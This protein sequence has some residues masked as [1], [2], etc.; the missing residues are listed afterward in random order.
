MDADTYLRSFRSTDSALYARMRGQIP[1]HRE[2]F[3]DTATYETIAVESLLGLLY[4][5]GMV[6]D[7]S[8][9]YQ[10]GQ[11]F[12]DVV[13]HEQEMVAGLYD[14]FGSPAM[15]KL[16]ELVGDGDAASVEGALL[17]DQL[18][19]TAALHGHGINDLREYSL[20]VSSV[21]RKGK[22]VGRKEQAAGVAQAI[23][24][25]RSRRAQDLFP[26]R[27]I[28]HIARTYDGNEFVK[29]SFTS[30]FTDT[31]RNLPDWLT[32]TDNWEDILGKLG[33]MKGELDALT[34]L[35]E[36]VIDRELPVLPILAPYSAE[37]GQ[38]RGSVDGGNLHADILLLDMSCPQVYPVQIKNSRDMKSKIN[39]YHPEVAI[40]TPQDMGLVTATPVPVH[41]ARG[42]RTGLRTEAA[43]GGIS[44]PWRK[45]YAAK[46]RN[47]KAEK[48]LLA[49]LDPAFRSFDAQ[50]M[51]LIRKA[52][53]DRPK[54]SN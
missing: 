6:R 41:T 54:I 15:N 19:L 3:L 36:W 10:A 27:G 4:Q 34:A 32:T 29:G 51:P 38:Q 12:G 31:G 52:S 28:M 23:R 11:A 14:R 5:R 21:L 25:S 35:Q 47:K 30:R 26:M 50:I 1:A 37:R 8:A 46:Q 17:S 40:I 22:E 24:T 9:D 48:T 45:I 18:S 13:R 43:Y 39:S 20:S 53:G 33:S 49:K 7:L 16:V 42:V 2:A 44:E